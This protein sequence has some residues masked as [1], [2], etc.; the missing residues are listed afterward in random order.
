MIVCCRGVFTELNIP[1]IISLYVMQCDIYKKRNLTHK[2]ISAQ[3]TH[4]TRRQDKLTFLLY[5]YR[6]TTDNNAAKTSTTS[7]KLFDLNH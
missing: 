3:H 4:L 1:T 6:F 7:L 2:T 5:L